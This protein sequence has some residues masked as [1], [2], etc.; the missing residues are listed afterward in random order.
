MKSKDG[1]MMGENWIE[2]KRSGDKCKLSFKDFC[3][4][5]LDDEDVD[6][7]IKRLENFQF[8][9]ILYNYGLI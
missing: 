5:I 8:E 4:I 7:M 6:Y 3:D 2:I 9:K 1:L